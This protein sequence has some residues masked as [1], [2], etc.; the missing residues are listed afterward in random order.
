MSPTPGTLAAPTVRS[1]AAI[2]TICHVL[3]T[4]PA[5]I[6]AATE[7]TKA[8]LSELDD[9]CSR[10]RADSELSSLPRG[11]E[12]A[13]TPLLTELLAVALDTARRTGGL[14][15]PT[16]SLRRLGY[17]AD[18][19]VVR[20][21]R[22]HA[23]RKDSEHS[24]APGYWRILLDQPRRR[25]LIP[26][27]LEVDLGASAKAWAADRAARIC[28][29]TLPGGFLVNLGGDLAL[30]GDPPAPGWQVALDDATGC[31]PEDWPV[32]TLSRGGAATSSTVVRTWKVAGSPFHHIVDP[33]TGRS[34]EPVWRTVTVTAES[35]AL[36]NA[37]ATAA[38]VLGRR[39]AFWLAAR[40]LPA[41]LVS[42]DG[43]PVYVGDW[44]IERPRDR[45]LPNPMPGSGPTR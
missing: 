23:A 8:Q 18:L 25:V 21:R 44:P 15:D 37:A 45:V 17:D 10:F 42:V 2:G 9:A 39:A 6:L 27:G 29:A 24:A 26:E 13:I 30:A 28:G 14:V 40:A 19:D 34:A 5:S 16:V 12:V 3:S 32:V 38:V 11:R 4:D 7:I 41:R 33:R 20:A 31:D 35:A 22:P 43:L 1:F 36:A